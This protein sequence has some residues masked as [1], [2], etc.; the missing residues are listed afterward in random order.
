MVSLM[1]ISF[2]IVGHIHPAR[3]RVVFGGRHTDRQTLFQT[4]Y[5]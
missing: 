4:V 2:R 5:N 3:A 1:T